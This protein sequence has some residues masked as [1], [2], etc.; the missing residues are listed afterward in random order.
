MYS[1][2]SSM[3]S[4]PT[5]ENTMIKF[6]AIIFFA[7]G[8]AKLIFRSNKNKAIWKIHNN[9]N[10]FPTHNYTPS[11]YHMQQFHYNS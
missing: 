8:V 6:L 1:S 4:K 10:G 2:F 11:K 5:S 3:I 9:S 7:V